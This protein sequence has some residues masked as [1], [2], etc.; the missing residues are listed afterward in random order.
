MRFSAV[1]LR[2]RAG[3]SLQ[4]CALASV[5][6][7]KTPAGPGW[8]QW[9]ANVDELV[10]AAQALVRKCYGGEIVD[11]EDI[12]EEVEALKAAAEP[13]SRAASPD[14]ASAG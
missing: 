13:F 4:R 11:F 5:G 9:N 1:L 7:T 10:K 6:Q 3:C 12:G 8:S 2:H 14:P